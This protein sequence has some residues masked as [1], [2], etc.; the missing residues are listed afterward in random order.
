MPFDQVP[1]PK[2]IFDI[3]Q[4]QAAGNKAAA[5][6]AFRR[7]GEAVGDAL[8]QALTLVDGLA[9]I[10][11]GISASWP[12]FLPALVDELNSTYTAP[13]GTRFR[14]L[15]QVAFNLEDEAQRARF[16]KGESRE[17]T[18][19]GSTRK[20]NYDPLSRLAVGISR[21]GTSE[22][23]AIGACAFALRKLDQA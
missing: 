20:L 3:G 7:L 6:E 13:N 16:L 5:L 14:R 15:V 9:V 21:L 10:G 12:L 2:V 8:G 19:P 17:I 22:A 23:V 18:V 11:G 1:E 4:G